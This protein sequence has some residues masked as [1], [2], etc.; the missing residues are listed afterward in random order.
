MES[1]LPE[2]DEEEEDDDDALSALKAMATLLS[3]SSSSMRTRLSNAFF[4]L[5]S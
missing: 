3:F 1:T 4:S 5:L 2:A